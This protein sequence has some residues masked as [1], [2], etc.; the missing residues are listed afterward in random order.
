MAKCH[1]CDKPAIVYLED[2]KIALC[3]DC[4]L[5]LQQ[6]FDIE[7]RRNAARINFLA[8]EFESSLGCSGIIPRYHIPTPIYQKGDTTFNNI[9][10]SNSAVGAINTG[11]VKS[12]D[13]SLTHLKQ[14]GVDELVDLIKRFTEEILRDNKIEEKQ[15]NELLEHVAFISEQ[16]SISK[17]Q[18]KSIIL[19]SVFSYVTSGISG[20]E[21]LMNI[22]DKIRAI[23]IHVIK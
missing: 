20:I 17:D 6:I 3:L 16:I 19:K 14:Q 11:N 22:W 15:R 2:N 18:R 9:N 21:S 7:Q 5:K 12:I 23:L 13:V 10:I 4:N 1:Q 8:D